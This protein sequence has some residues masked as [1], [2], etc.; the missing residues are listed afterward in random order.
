MVQGGECQVDSCTMR[1]MPPPVATSAAYTCE[2]S[3]E[4]PKF[5]IARETKHMTVVGESSLYDFLK[6]LFIL[7]VTLIFF[8]YTSLY[9]FYEKFF[10]YPFQSKSNLQ[11]PQ[12]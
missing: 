10:L 7:I 9:Y 6:I 2:V 3:T 1:V 11:G 12:E 8:T 5:Q 4:G